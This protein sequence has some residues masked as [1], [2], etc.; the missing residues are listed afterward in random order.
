MSAAPELSLPEHVRVSIT[1]T[2]DILIARQRSRQL[3]HALG[4]SSTD[5]TFI[6]TAVSALARNIVQFA[7]K[8]E[9]VFAPIEQAGRNGILVIASDHGPGMPTVGEILRNQQDRPAKFGVGLAGVKRF[10]D[11]VEI[12][13]SPGQGTTI[14]A[15]KWLP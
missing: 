4:F 8:G 11:E 7:K 6:A 5:L 14:T 10:M 2:A 3:G 13:S 9:M 1:S 12:E 15:R